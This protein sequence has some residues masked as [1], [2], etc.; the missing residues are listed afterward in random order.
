MHVSADHADFPFGLP[1][2]MRLLHRA[3]HCTLWNQK[4]QAPV[5]WLGAEASSSDRINQLSLPCVSSLSLSLS[6]PVHLPCIRLAKQE[7]NSFRTEFELE[8]KFTLY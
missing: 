6:T 8:K 3:F 5:F 7:C 4:R 2:P 1:L